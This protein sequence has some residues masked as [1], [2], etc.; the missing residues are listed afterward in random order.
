[1]TITN[2]SY[3]RMIYNIGIIA[4]I[5]FV[6]HY[7]TINPNSK[8]VEKIFLNS[9]KWIGFIQVSNAFWLILPKYKFL[10]SHI[11]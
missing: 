9:I 11:F 1:M 2:L 6:N 4:F 10:S 8:L 5:V 3:L 7:G